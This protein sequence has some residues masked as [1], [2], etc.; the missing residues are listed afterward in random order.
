MQLPVKI[1]FRDIA[2][3]PE[4]ETKIRERAA[5][6]QKTYPQ[7]TG[8]RVSL[9]VPHR[10]KVRG[11]AYHIGIDISVPDHEIIVDRQ[12][13]QTD[14]DADL[15]AAISDAFD[16]AR[17]QLEDYSREQRG[18]VKSHAGVPRARIVQLFP[19]AGYGFLETADGR[20]IYFHHHSLLGIDFDQLEIGSRVSFLEEAGDKGPQAAWVR[21]IPT[22]KTASTH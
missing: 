7:I 9:S 18:N 13:M 6:L 2:H 14:T 21:V 11:N 20:E 8:C 12:T 15:S 17:R 4:A 19:A 5:K 3:S 1:I 22:P 10:H 16:A